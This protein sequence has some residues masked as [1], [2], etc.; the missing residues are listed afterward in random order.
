MGKNIRKRLKMQGKEYY[1]L[2]AKKVKEKEIKEPCKCRK[3]C[4]EQLSISER[5]EIFKEFYN[6]SSEAQ[7]QFIANFVEEQN[8]KV[9]RKRTD[10][11]ASR[12]NFT[13]KYFLLKSNGRVEVCQTMFLNTLD[14]NLK[15]VRV[16]TEKKRHS[17]SGICPEDMR[18]KHKNHPKVPEKDK[19]E[20]RNHIKMF[21]SYESHY[22]RS[23]TKKKYLPSDL[24]ISQ[25][26]RLYVSH[27]MEKKL[28]PE[29][30]DSIDKFLLKSLICPFINQP[31]I[32]VGLVINTTF[33]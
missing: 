30:K 31:T 6:L 9:E 12:R 17:E 21:P 33:C 19:E 26:H 10:N 29:M 14:L 22:S 23:H 28:L 3:K 18:G 8:K 20:I 2:S 24:S 15:K 5:E 1:T 11:G 25:M 16:I 4:Y 27:C 7:N 13:R 32:P